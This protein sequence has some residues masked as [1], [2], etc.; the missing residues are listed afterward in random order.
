MEPCGIAFH[1]TSDYASKGGENRL[2]ADRRSGVVVVVVVVVVGGWSRTR[3][4]YTFALIIE[5]V[6]IWA[7]GFGHRLL[8][9]S[10]HK[11]TTTT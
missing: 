7:G 2:L 6:P 8:F 1:I 3:D 4:R 5:F 10:R 9:A 11:G